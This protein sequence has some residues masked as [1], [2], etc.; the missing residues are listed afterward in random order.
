MLWSECS[1]MWHYYKKGFPFS[2]R[3][4]LRERP[5]ITYWWDCV[6]CQDFSIQI[7]LVKHSKVFS[8]FFFWCLRDKRTMTLRPVNYL[9]LGEKRAKSAWQLL[10]FQDIGLENC[11]TL[12]EMRVKS[13]GYKG[14]NTSVLCINQIFFILTDNQSIFCHNGFQK[15]ECC[16]LA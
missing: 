7:T 11:T 15:L 2:L 9:S 4:T 5:S 16:R 10:F 14:Q 13:L 8:K 3:R 12:I 6:K 1:V